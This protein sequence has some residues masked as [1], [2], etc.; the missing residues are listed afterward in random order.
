MSDTDLDAFIADTSNR[1]EIFWKEKLKPNNGWAVPYVT[2][3]RYRV[4]WA[5]DLDYTR[6]NVQV[7][8]RWQPADKEV[9]FMLPFVDAR[10]AINVTRTDT[11][12][13]IMD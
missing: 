6:M 3:H 1:S 5:N 8:E 11:G 2:G 13:Q 4:T 9:I 10:E 12:E 7:S